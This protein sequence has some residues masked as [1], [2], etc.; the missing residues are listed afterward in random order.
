MIIS[1]DRW[2]QFEEIFKLCTIVY[3]RREDDEHTGNLIDEK[4]CEYREKYGA[5]IERLVTLP[6]EMS[7]TEIRMAVGEGRDISAFVPEK[8]AEYIKQNQLYGG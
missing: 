3:V 8:V 4:I 1:F 6:L 5:R 2:Y 7:S